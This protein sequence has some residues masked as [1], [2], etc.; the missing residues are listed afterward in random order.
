MRLSAPFETNG[1]DTLCQPQ[2][3]RLHIVWQPSDLV[4]DR[5]IKGFYCPRYGV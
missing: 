1:L 4:V 5:G 2:E 3:P